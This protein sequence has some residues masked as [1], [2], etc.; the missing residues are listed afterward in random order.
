VVPRC[1]SLS[2]AETEARQ[3]GEAPPPT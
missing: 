3:I 2:Y 1:V